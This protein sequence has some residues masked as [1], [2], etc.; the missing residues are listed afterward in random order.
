MYNY[1]NDMQRYNYISL[2]PWSSCHKS[3]HLQLHLEARLHAVEAVWPASCS[4]V[5]CYRTTLIWWGYNY[6]ADC[7][8]YNNYCVTNSFSFSPNSGRE[9]HSLTYAQ[10]I[11]EV[12][13][14]TGLHIY[15]AAAGYAPSQ[16]WSWY[17]QEMWQTA[18]T[19]T[20]LQHTAD[21]NLSRH[22]II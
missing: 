8:I 13:A 15:T 10:I 1:R 7:I 4:I 5:M 22:S 20:K 2:L 12:N 3:S 18:F 17:I 14:V 9:Q 6:T 21:T 16:Y 11:E 19:N